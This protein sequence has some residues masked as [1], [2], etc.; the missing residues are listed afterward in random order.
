MDKLVK[1][2][3]IKHT[4]GI[5]RVAIFGG[6]DIKKDDPLY[7]EVYEICAR[8]AKLGKV[9]VDGGGP[10]LMEAATQGAKS[11]GGKV[12]TVTF[13]PVDMPGFEGRSSNNMPDEEIQTNT[14]IERMFGLMEQADCF[15]C[16]RGGTGTL[17]E[18]AT[19][20]LLAHLHYPHYKPLILYGNFWHQIMETINKNFLIDEVEKKVY[21]IVDSIDQLF[22]VLGQ[23]E[24]ETR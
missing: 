17:S 12:V 20:W 7:C 8:L 13:T 10:G 11:A 18:W 2:P 23:L 15:V 14:Y 1:L 4:S 5:D 21:R 19:A 22:E 6:A 16:V 3:H 24:V 9:V